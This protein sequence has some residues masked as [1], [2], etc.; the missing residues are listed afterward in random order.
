[1]CAVQELETGCRVFAPSTA[2]ACAWRSLAATGHAHAHAPRPPTEKMADHFALATCIRA[3]AA[4]Q[5]NAKRTLPFVEGESRGKLFALAR[6]IKDIA[7]GE[8]D[9]GNAAT[10]TIEPRFAT[11]I[12]AKIDSP[13]RRCKM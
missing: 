12:K 1:M 11:L 9:P 6:C 5:V 10:T 3:V 7:S 8:V 4:G 2:Q 13:A